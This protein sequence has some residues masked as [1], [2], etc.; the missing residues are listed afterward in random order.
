[1]RNIKPTPICSSYHMDTHNRIFPYV[2]TDTHMP[3]VRGCTRARQLDDARTSRPGHSARGG[4]GRQRDECA[5][6]REK[7]GS[8]M[9]KSVTC[10]NTKRERG[11]K[12]ELSLAS[13]KCAGIPFPL[14]ETLEELGALAGG[15]IEPTHLSARGCNALRLAWTRSGGGGLH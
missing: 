14:G 1:M 10:W 4:T 11:R 6:H 12:K 13:C 5:G 2:K 3:A 9:P 15:R 7:P 8:A